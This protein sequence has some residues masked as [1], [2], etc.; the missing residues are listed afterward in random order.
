[1][2]VER[3]G[4]CVQHLRQSRLTEEC[5]AQR[6]EA[7]QVRSGS[8]QPRVISAPVCSSSPQRK[9]RGKAKRS[10]ISKES[11]RVLLFLCEESLSVLCGEGL[12]RFA[13]GAKRVQVHL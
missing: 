11:P 7:V 5:L 2:E 9:T 3:G 12:L 10:C 6:R 13:E 8:V 4:I 1:M